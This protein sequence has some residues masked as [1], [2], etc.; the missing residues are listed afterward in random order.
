MPFHVTCNDLP[1]HVR[2]A[3]EPFPKVTGERESLDEYLLEHDHVR[4][5]NGQWVIEFPKIIWNEAPG[6]PK[7]DPWR[8]SPDRDATLGTARHVI[9]VLQLEA[10]KFDLCVD[11]CREFGARRAIEL[12]IGVLDGK[13]LLEH[14]EFLLRHYA[15]GTTV[16][17]ARCFLREVEHTHTGSDR[18]Y[19]PLLRAI[20]LNEDGTASRVYDGT[21]A[22]TTRLIAREYSAHS[23]RPVIVVDGEDRGL[24]YDVPEYGPT[25][26][27]TPLDFGHYTFAGE[28]IAE[29][30]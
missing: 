5:L 4:R 26:R 6:R 11:F 21:D 25:P 13:E 14:E 20:A 12:S 23:R 17:G 3:I 18:V 16:S 8:G 1:L 10:A 27:S 24:L 30:L 29:V 9:V 15:P 7:Y 19:A 22:R 28:L 2:K